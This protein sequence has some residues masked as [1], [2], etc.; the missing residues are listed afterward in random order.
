MYECSISRAFDFSGA[1]GGWDYNHCPGPHC[2]PRHIYGVC[3]W[4]TSADDY[5]FFNNP[6][7]CSPFGL[8]Q[9]A[10]YSTCRIWVS[11]TN[12]EQIY[13]IIMPLVPILTFG[14]PLCR[15][16]NT[17]HCLNELKNVFY[18][19]HQLKIFLHL[20]CQLP[21]WPCSLPT[22]VDV[23]VLLGDHLDQYTSHVTWHREFPHW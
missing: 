11:V 14:S 12:W 2:P 22:H 1:F 7:A 21:L 6:K 10:K 4:L 19:T 17:D 3:L 16:R 8:W 5:I 23:I 18:K 9:A 13:T 20:F 15:V